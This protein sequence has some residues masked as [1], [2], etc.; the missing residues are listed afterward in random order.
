[1]ALSRQ[2]SN[3][4]SNDSASDTS[5]IE[6][7]SQQ[8]IGRMLFNAMR[9]AGTTIEGRF[10]TNEWESAGSL[11]SS[12]EWDYA[13]E[14][15]TISHDVDQGVGRT[16]WQFMRFAG[17]KVEILTKKDDV[18]A[19]PEEAYARIAR[20]RSTEV[21]RLLN[22]ERRLTAH[23]ARILILGGSQAG[24][25]TIVKQMKIQYGGSY[26]TL[27]RESF[28]SAILFNSAQAME[29]VVEALRRVDL[30]LSP[31]NNWHAQTLTILSTSGNIHG[32][33]I[34]RELL[35]AMVEDT[36]VKLAMS[37]LQNLD[38]EDSALYFLRSIDRIISAEYVPTNEDI[39]HSYQKTT[40]ITETPIPLNSVIYK[41][42]DPP[43]NSTLRNKRNKWISYLDMVTVLLFVVALSDYDQTLDGDPSVN[44]LD[45]TLKLF[46]SICTSP[47]LSDAD[48]IIMFF[49]K[50]DLFRAK[51]P[52][53][54]LKAH[55]PDYNGENNE[56]EVTKYFLKHMKK[57]AKPEIFMH[58]TNLTEMNSIPMLPKT[59]R[60]VV[61]EKNL[62]TIML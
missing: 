31:E 53:S 60:D 24:K 44:K 29:S 48:G 12:S 45:E 34:A 4:S 40:S 39:L 41:F 33:Y 42:Y 30:Q 20:A 16:A 50:M 35:A 46:E 11:L 25:S 22:K 1:M 13:S 14:S 57:S 10:L 26:N 19:S 55:I 56:D 47:F 8:G 2:N 51:L 36:A 32:A 18:S 3:Y 49:N 54:P 5:T 27:E 7:D 21:D 37:Q 28:K 23:E 6:Q 17:E 9:L 52:H 38:L 15:S 58:R 59:I 62:K 43:S 61:F